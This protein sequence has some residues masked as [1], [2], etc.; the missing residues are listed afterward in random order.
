MEKKKRPTL[1]YG[2]VQRTLIPGAEVYLEDF[3]GRMGTRKMRYSL[4]GVKKGDLLVNMDS[5]APNKVCEEALLDDSLQLP[6]MGK[7]PFVKREKPLAT[8]ALIFT[9]KTRMV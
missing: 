7:L 8:L 9:W 5:Q 4:I 2:Q 3:Y 6:G 1:K